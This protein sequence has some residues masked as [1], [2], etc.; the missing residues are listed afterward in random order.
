LTKRNWT[1]LNWADRQPH[2]GHENVLINYIYEPKGMEGKGEDETTLLGQWRL[3]KHSI[4]PI[5]RGDFHTNEADTSEHVFYVL[6]GRGQIKLD[7]ESVD[8]GVGDAVHVPP[9]VGHQSINNGDEWL[10]PLVISA[11]TKRVGQ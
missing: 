1:K 2:A 6:G 9:S 8:I 3:T 11:S 10:E 7:E 5:K 4:Q